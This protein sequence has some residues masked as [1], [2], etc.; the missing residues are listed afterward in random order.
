MGVTPADFHLAQEVD[1]IA[2]LPLVSHSGMFLRK[3]VSKIR[4]CITQLVKKWIFPIC[5]PGTR[6]RLGFWLGV[7]DG[8]CESELFFLRRLLFKPG[9][10]ID[11]GANQGLYSFQMSKIFPRVL[12]FEIN[13]TVSQDLKALCPRKISVFNRGLSSSERQATLFTPVLNGLP[14]LGWASLHKNSCPATNDHTESLVQ[15]TT[16]DSFHFSD[17][18]FIKIDVEGHELAVLQGAIQTIRH[19]QPAVLVELR[20]ENRREALAFFDGLAYKERKMRFPFGTTESE[21]ALFFPANY[22]PHIARGKR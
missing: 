16:L 12:A 19:N 4:G 8:S 6:I 20:K 21:N 2:G 11:V 13:E 14:L 9:V 18:S 15:V 5:T 10:G 17:V 22:R 1:V 3:W 7:F